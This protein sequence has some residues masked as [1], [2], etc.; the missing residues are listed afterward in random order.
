MKFE[1]ALKII[2]DEP[3]FGSDILSVDYP[4]ETELS[5]QIARW[6]RSGYLLQ[7]RRGLYALSKDY[8]KKRPHPF[9]IANR[10]K[11]ASYVSLHSALAHHGLIPEHVPIVT[12][13]TTGRPEK[14]T[15]PLGGFLFKHVKPGLFFGYEVMDAGD[16]QN[17]FIAKPEKAFLDLAY[18]TPGSDDPEYV[19]GLRLQ[20]LSVLG[21]GSLFNFAEMSGSRKL[22]RAVRIFESIRSELEKS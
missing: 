7:L 3:V 19:R 8:H 22:I 10:L 4:N 17:V 2:G 13:V 9:Y 12:S 1:D 6:V 14:R 18:L 15:T 20:N 16:G 21:K 11:K 5:R